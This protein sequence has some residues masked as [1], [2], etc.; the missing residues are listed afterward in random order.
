MRF[1][2]VCWLSLA[3][4]PAA[5][6]GEPAVAPSDDRGLAA[7]LERMAST[8]G[9]E[10]TYVERRELSLLVAPLDSRGV[11][12]FVPPDRFARFTLEP[13]YSSLVADGDGLRLREGRNA[14]EMDLSGSPLARGFVESFTVLWSGDRDELERLYAVELRDIGPAG[15]EP[16]EGPP[17]RDVSWELRLS[18]R[19]APLSRVITAITLRGGSGGTREMV[20]EEEDGD[21][22]V[23]TFEWI[24][25][26]RAFADSELRR[27]FEAREPLNGSESATPEP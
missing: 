10:A 3:L 27:I 16:G 12:Y 14:E 13:G 11:I 1:S 5:F 22:T 15:V 6:A 7:L 25:A 21:R 2:V 8:A 26:D 18:P 9:V 24:R 4:A 20:V 19:H 23:T 17:A